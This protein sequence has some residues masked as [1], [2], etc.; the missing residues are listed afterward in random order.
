M[1]RRQLLQGT[2]SLT[3]LSL[4]GL[5]KLATAMVPSVA[6]QLPD[7]L[8][9]NPLLD[10]YGLP[11]YSQIKAND[12]VPAIEFLIEQ[13]KSQIAQV[14][15]NPA[16]NWQSYYFGLFDTDDKL[17]KAWGAVAN[18]HALRNDDALRDAYAKAQQSL[19]EYSTWRGMHKGL[20][21]TVTKI[22]NSA[23]FAT[24][25]IAEQKSINDVLRDFRL[26]GI[27]LPSDQQVRLAQ[28]NTRLSELSTAF[29]NNV[30]DATNGWSKIVDE[31]ALT[32]L[33]AAALESAKQKAADKGKSGY[34]I[35]LDMPSYMA[36]MNY[37]DD[38]KLREEMYR[39]FSTKA[40]DQGA[41]AGKWDNQPVIA[42][43][44]Q[45]RL[46]MAQLLGFKNY[47]EY[48]LATKM[49]DTPQQV[50]EFLT[51]LAMRSRDQAQAQIDEL[52][53]FAKQEYGKEMLNAW[54][55]SYYTEKHKAKLYD[56]D[57]EKLREYFP[58][59]KVLTGLFAILQRLFGIKV[60]EKSADVWDES[61]R[62]FEVYD[63]A[64]RQKAAF[65]LDLYARDN[66]R[67]G[68]WM[69]TAIDRVRDAD[70]RVQLPVAV[71]ACN[72]R[73]PA[74]GQ[75]SLL[76]HD[77]VTTLFHE[78]GH[79]LNLMLTQMDVMGVTGLNGVPW[80]VV[81]VPSQLMEGFALDRTTLPMISAHYKTGESLPDEMLDKLIEAKHYQGAF[82]LTR[83]L[84]FGIFDMRV[85]SEYT[86]D[87]PTNFAQQLYL[88]V[89]KQI[90]VLAMPDYVR[91]PN[92][93]THVFSGGYAAGYYSYLWAELLAN[94][95]FAKFEEDGVLSPV[96][97]KRLE[98][99]I[100]GQG[101]SR[102]PMDLFVEFRGRAPKLDALLA[103][104]GIQ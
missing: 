28:I 59:D 42:E 66:K 64:N 9:D 14:V 51:G 101:G 93:F 62:F 41:N 13:S 70:G 95:G 36:V 48:S 53:D 45:L 77:E 17:S 12:V 84:E 46:E 88:D 85:N 67:D 89:T 80:D 72:F 8:L 44:L 83:Q 99:T 98:D 15:A 30:L 61:V 47:A 69:S 94:D 32:G 7:H 29:S 71:L 97:G 26:S 4:V 65:Y 54:D 52:R 78:F 50:M 82:A 16:P 86:A 27:D 81:E 37:A 74:D 43:I 3:A 63:A 35:G 87:K 24:L 10:F 58:E 49:A 22:K 56:F 75:P 5:P 1:K 68:A 23:E 20:F 102:S 25:S 31:A 90:G 2:L 6:M 55:V 34:Y 79:G 96:T 40:S 21:D 76:L 100:M 104:Y 11:K 73:K 92:F 39:A 33:N 19:T 18:L 38:E 57:K 91:R 60:R 103:N